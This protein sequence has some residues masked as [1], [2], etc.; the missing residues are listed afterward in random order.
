MEKHMYKYWHP[1]S[2]TYSEVPIR[3]RPVT[4]KG[5]LECASM[6]GEVYVSANNQYKHTNIHCLDTPPYFREEPH[7]ILE[8]C[9]NLFNLIHN[10]VTDKNDINTMLFL[11]KSARL[12]EYTFG[13]FWR[14]MEKQR[15]ARDIE[16][17]NK[18][19]IRFINPEAEGLRTVAMMQFGLWKKKIRDRDFTGN[20]L[21]VDEYV[22]SGSTVFRAIKTLR[23]LDPVP[24]Q[25]EAIQMFWGCPRWY[26]YSDIKGVT[27][28]SLIPHGERGALF[29]KAAGGILAIPPEKDALEES[30]LYRYAL[31]RTVQEAFR[32]KL[33]QA[34]S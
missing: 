12:A 19:A 11:D 24:K 28:L 3:L 1:N 32:L 27:T 7:N 4:L 10:R 31:K 29:D 20:I 8:G 6:W 16:L 14:E 25:I 9:V 2:S 13:V 5:M 23:R 33:I 15:F 21:I 30:N 17:P 18:P 22:N 26:K 34:G